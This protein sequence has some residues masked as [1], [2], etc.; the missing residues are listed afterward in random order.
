MFVLR[1]PL[2]LGPYRFPPSALC[3]ISCLSFVLRAMRGLLDLNTRCS[4]SN[5]FEFFGLYSRYTLE[6]GSLQ[7]FIWDTMTFIL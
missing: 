4:A 1:S 2:P 3:I 7:F 5:G 6:A